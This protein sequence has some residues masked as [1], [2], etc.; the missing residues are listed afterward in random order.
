MK[1]SGL[2]AGLLAALAVGQASA[3]SFELQAGRE[4]KN[5]S[6]ATERF[7]SQRVPALPWA[8]AAVVPAKEFGSLFKCENRPALSIELKGDG[9][10][11][12]N[13]DNLVPDGADHPYKGI[14]YNCSFADEKTF[15]IRIFGQ[16]GSVEVDADMTMAIVDGGRTLTVTKNDKSASRGKRI[17]EDETYTCSRAFFQRW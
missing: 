1:T 11:T 10:V 7:R 6:A 12:V 8:Q 3:E 14:Q 2:L 17:G 16:L 9:T 13:G 15:K 4:I 5:L